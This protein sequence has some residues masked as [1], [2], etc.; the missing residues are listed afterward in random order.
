LVDARNLSANGS[1]SV[2]IATPHQN[3]TKRPSDPDTARPRTGQPDAGALKSLRRFAT[4]RN[5]VIEE[6][7]RELLSQPASGGDA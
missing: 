1:I 3:G 7:A 4:R 5:L 2:A 6:L